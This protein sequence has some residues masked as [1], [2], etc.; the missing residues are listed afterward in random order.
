MTRLERAIMIHVHICR[1]KSLNQAN[2]MSSLLL[3]SFN[4]S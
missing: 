4:W 3:W 1:V 2:Q